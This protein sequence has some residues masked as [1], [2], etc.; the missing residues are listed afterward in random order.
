MYRYEP[1]HVLI[2]MSLYQ[3]HALLYAFLLLMYH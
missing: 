3:A 2:T 1:M